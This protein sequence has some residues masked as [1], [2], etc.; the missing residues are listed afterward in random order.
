MKKAYEPDAERRF[1]DRINPWEK[2]DQHE[3]QPG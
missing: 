3:T 2:E 1:A